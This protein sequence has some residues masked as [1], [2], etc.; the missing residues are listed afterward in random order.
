MLIVDTGPI[1]AAAATRDRHHAVCTALLRRASRP[2]LVPA[3]VVTEVAYLLVDRIGADAEVAFA[4]SISS[5][6]LLVEPVSP[7]DWE[8]I[9]ELVARYRDMAL[10]IVDASIVALAERLDT[11]TIATLDKRHFSAIRPKHVEMFNLVPTV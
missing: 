11:A 6:E 5:G 7:R 1:Y 2:L 3:L 9:L 8:R 10:G 4:K